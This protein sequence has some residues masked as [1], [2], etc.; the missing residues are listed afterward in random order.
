MDTGTRFLLEHRG[1][2]ETRRR[3]STAGASLWWRRFF[4]E[5]TTTSPNGEDG[6]MS[7]S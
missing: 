3:Q 5:S 2:K 7:I 1:S 4:S 6:I